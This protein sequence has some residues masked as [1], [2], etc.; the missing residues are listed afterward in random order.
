MTTQGAKF[1]SLIPPR[2]NYSS[3]IKYSANVNMQSGACNI[4][5]GVLPVP[6][7]DIELWMPTAAIY[8]QNVANG[9][10]SDD[11]VVF[12]YDYLGQ[13]MS[14]TIV[15][16]SAGKKAFAM[17]TKFTT[18][19]AVEFDDLTW[20]SKFGLPY[21]GAST[22]QAGATLTAGSNTT[23]NDPRGTVVFTATPDGDTEYTLAYVVDLTK[24]LYGIAHVHA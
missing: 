24:P 6:G 22:A 18:A 12:G 20:G 21:V 7:D 11:A 16:G 9:H 13:L 23:T 8:G 3:E 19:G 4:S 17:V 1:R 14:E 5:L 10:V 15:H 2:S